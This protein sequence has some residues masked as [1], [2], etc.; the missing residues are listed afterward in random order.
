MQDVLIG[1][2][3]YLSL[4]LAAIL[5]WYGTDFRRA[6]GKTLKQALAWGLIFLGVIAAFGLWDQIRSTTVATQAT[7][8]DTG[9]IE[10][11]VAP[12]GHYHL[13]ATI[14]GVPVAF[15]VDTGASDLVLT[16][17]DAE[18]IGLPASE[19]AFH[20][21]AMTANGEVRTAPVRL[22][23][24][25]LGSHVDRNVMARVN[26]GVMDQSLLGMS[27]LNRFEQITISRGTLVLTR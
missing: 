19:L 3:A 10:I 16:K 15:V 13:T 20:G 24:V 18:R 4:L 9:D 6:L 14:N 26:G 27:Y 11:P 22:A 21:R 7:F 23:E 2:L 1:N 25:V 5:F 8:T 17:Q 12:D